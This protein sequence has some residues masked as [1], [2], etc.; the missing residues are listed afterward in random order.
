MLPAFEVQAGGL[1]YH[2]KFATAPG[3]EGTPLPWELMVVLSK[4]NKN[5]GGGRS[6]RRIY[7]AS[8]GEAAGDARWEVRRPGPIL[9]SQGPPTK[10]RSMLQR[11]GADREKGS[12][13][14]EGGSGTKRWKRGKRCNR[15]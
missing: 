10:G 11:T 8:A 6:L 2:N 3:K 1:Q 14:P 13:G 7:K 5:R 12:G 9:H 4:K 15:D